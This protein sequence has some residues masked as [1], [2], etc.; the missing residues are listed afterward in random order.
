MEY[1]VDGF[2]KAKRIEYN[3]GIRR[4]TDGLPKKTA[5]IGV[6]SDSDGVVYIRPFSKDGFFNSAVIIPPEEV[7]TLAETLLRIAAAQD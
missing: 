5:G 6:N 7:R 4:D 3:K 2:L 1:I